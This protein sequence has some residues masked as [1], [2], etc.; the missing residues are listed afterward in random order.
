MTAV[1]I[2]SVTIT[3]NVDGRPLEVFAGTLEA[4]EKYMA[5]VHTRDKAYIKSERARGGY[6][7]LYASM[8]EKDP[9]RMKL[10]K[11]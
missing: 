1:D 10:V 3:S 7:E 11:K 4:C 5:D 9:P 6:G 8:A 2:F